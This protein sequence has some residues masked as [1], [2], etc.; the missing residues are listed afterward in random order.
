M[1]LSKLAF[2]SEAAGSGNP[3]RV[4]LA[5]I[6]ATLISV[7]YIF[8]IGLI[9]QPDVYYFQDRITYHDAFL[10]N[11]V[12]SEFLLT[13]IIVTS[14]NAWLFLA[15]ERRIMILGVLAGISISLVAYLVYH[16][17]GLRIV[18]LASAP[19][20]ITILF[21]SYK[22]KSLVS[23][24][25]RLSEL[26]INYVC[27][28]V[29]L[30]AALSLVVSLTGLDAMK[31][32]LF[33]Q[34]F[35]LFSGL[36]PILVFLI[37]MSVPLR[38]LMY[39]VRMSIHRKNNYFRFFTYKSNVDA[40]A[41]I[42]YLSIF[43]SLS[44][45]LIIIPHLLHEDEQYIG[46]DTQAYL[47]LLSTLDETTNNNEYIS[48]LFISLGNGDR[49][50]SLL[51]FHQLGR[52]GSIERSAAIE[53][54]IPIIITP[55]LVIIT[56]FLC[57]EITNDDYSSLF[58]SFF[59][60]VSFHVLIGLHAGFFANWIALLPAYISILFLLRYLKSS[61]R[62][63]LS[64]FTAS[65]F[66]LLFTHVYT[67]TIV[68]LFLVLFLVFTLIRHIYQK[69]VI[70][71][72]IVIVVLCIGTDLVRSNMAGIEPGIAKD[73]SVAESANAGLS[74]FAA[75]WENLV[76]TIQV[77]V[78]GFYSNFTFLSLVLSGLLLARMTDSLWIFIAVFVSVAMLP[79]FFGNVV[80]LS[81]VLYD[82]PF[83]IPAAITLAAIMRTRNGKVRVISVLSAMSAVSFL[84]V[85][86]LSN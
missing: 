81:R 43:V 53:V 6:I 56:F 61:S 44:L 50:L 76:R 67:W 54:G 20:I 63:H 70:L 24:S 15:L 82:I 1:L 86:N 3:S 39:Y 5:S 59:S 45:I 13:V 69:K 30:L 60:A 28:L 17:A 36:S 9:F 85:A 58:A 11:A 46:I 77:H 79:L 22:V 18:A 8:L 49:P 52:V 71:T 84:L 34:I 35:V 29:I 65:L 27:F 74:Q 41:K 19:L 78:G 66:I 14:L 40:D 83:Q 4:I 21:Y 37:I 38:I 7:S 12:Y 31:F 42:A 68:T 48:Q 33:Y 16:E 10:K 80:I 55:A 23:S 25:E 73:L 75:R 26:T 47:D 64:I 72:S 62:W 32:D 57:R 51:L 2:I